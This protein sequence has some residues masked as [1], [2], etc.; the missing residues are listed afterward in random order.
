[1]F[2]GMTRIMGQITEG[3]MTP[4]GYCVDLLSDLPEL[5]ADCGVD[6]DV[7]RVTSRIRAHV[8]LLRTLDHMD[9]I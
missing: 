3:M 2:M 6:E 1:M 4:Q 7:E 8:L 5:D 9:S